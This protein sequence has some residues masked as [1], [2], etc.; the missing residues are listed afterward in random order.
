MDKED[1]AKALVNLDTKGQKEQELYTQN[2]MDQLN[3]MKSNQVGQYGID[4]ELGYANARAYKN[5][6]ALQGAIGTDTPFG[7]FEYAKTTTPTGIENSA[8]LSNQLPIG[9]GT[10][11]VD[12]LKSL[13]TPERTATLGYNAPMGRGQFQAR[14]M[15]GQDAERQKIKE[16]QMQYLQQL[17]K[18]M[19]VGVYGKKTPYDQSIGL[20]LQG[21]F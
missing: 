5:P 4:N 19:G 17:N 3:R 2:M 20:Q 1:M 14:A 7:N 9:N 13:N 6:N 15:T 12:L 11:Q 18:N 21:R 16:M 10:A 8:M